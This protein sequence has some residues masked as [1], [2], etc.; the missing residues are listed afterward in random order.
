MKV[1]LAP[2]YRLWMWAL[3]P[4]TFGAGTVLLWALSLRWPRTIEADGLTLR[5]GRALPWT[6]IS[7][8][9]LRG[10]Y[11]D[12][13]ITR[14]DVHHGRHRFRISVNALGNGQTVAAAI[15]AFFKSARR[16]RRANAVSA[17]II[18]DA[19]GLTSPV[20]VPASEA[21]PRNSSLAA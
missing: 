14:I 4:A 3:L 16:S 13:R 15:V 10:D 17:P 5:N 11:A 6:Q 21:A 9:K 2:G 18:L 7:A 1:S 20:G 19:P 12:G 8:I